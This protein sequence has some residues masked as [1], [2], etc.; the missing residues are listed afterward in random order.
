MFTTED[1]E[2]TENIFLL[3][4]LINKRLKLCVLCVLCGEPDSFLLSLRKAAPSTDG[5][6]VLPLADGERFGF[7]SA[8]PVVVADVDPSGAG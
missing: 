3:N 6:A 1:T 8:A 4:I 7:Q 2:D 5:P